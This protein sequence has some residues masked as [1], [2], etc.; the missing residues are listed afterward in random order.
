MDGVFYPQAL[1]ELQPNFLDPFHTGPGGG[2]GRGA[3]PNASAHLLHAGAAIENCRYPID[4]N[5]GFETKWNYLTEM[6]K[7][8][9]LLKLEAILHAEN[10]NGKLAIRSAMSIFGIARSRSSPN[11]L[12]DFKTPSPERSKHELSQASTVSRD[13]SSASRSFEGEGVATTPLV[14]VHAPLPPRVRIK[15]H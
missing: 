10:G 9:F 14:E 13:L 1:W 2:A 4:L 8:V 3:M 15:P 6:R 12:A 5:A 11:K 7:A